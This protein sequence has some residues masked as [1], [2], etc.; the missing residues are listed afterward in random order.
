MPREPKEPDFDPELVTSVSEI[1]Y[2]ERLG[3]TDAAK[4]IADDG[5]GGVKFRKRAAAY[6]ALTK[7]YIRAIQAVG[8]DAK[9]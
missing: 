7:A 9:K 3:E 5:D 6:D 4:M 2:R 1:V 8:L